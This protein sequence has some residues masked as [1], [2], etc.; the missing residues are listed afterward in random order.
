V[1][2]ALVSPY[3]WTYPGGVNGHV[4]AL[5]REL[6]RAGDEVSVLAPWDP[7]DRLSRVLHRRPATVTSPPE[8]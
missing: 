3:S 6:R 4:A 8:G 2:V 5:A 1:R 7:P